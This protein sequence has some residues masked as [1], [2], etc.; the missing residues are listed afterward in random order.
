[1]RKKS[2]VLVLAVLIIFALTGC[3]QTRSYIMGMI[4][5]VPS[6]Y[7]YP[8]SRIGRNEISFIGEGLS[9]ESVRQSELVA[10][11]NLFEKL[12]EYVGTELGR[13]YYRDL[14][15]AGAIEDLALHVVVTDKTYLE[16]S[17]QYRTILLC[18]ASEEIM[19][20]L[21]TESRQ[22]EYNREKEVI[23]LVDEGDQCIKNSQDL[24]AVRLYLQ[25]MILSHGLENLED[26]YDYESILKEV[27]QILSTL[28]MKIVSSNQ[29]EA[30]CSVLVERRETILKTK[31]DMAD[32]LASY[33]CVDG[34]GN[35]WEDS[36]AFTSDSDGVFRFRSVNYTLT[37]VGQI[38]FTFNIYDEIS[39]IRAF[40]E[41]T[42]E[43]LSR[44]VEEKRTVFSYDKTLN[45]TLMGLVVFTYDS[46][47]N[48]EENQNWSDYL[49]NRLISDSLASFKVSYTEQADLNLD[50]DLS[51]SEILSYLLKIEDRDIETALILRMGPLRQS[52]AAGVCHTVVEGKAVFYFKLDSSTF[53][54]SPVLN[55]SGFGETAEEAL[56]NAYKNI[57]NIIYDWLKGNYV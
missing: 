12:E 54:E 43:E 25:S 48:R 46:S 50:G 20:N 34:L 53:R 30:S 5:D 39:G 37:T 42:A 16:K 15:N 52:T 41:E 18:A 4:K 26:G 56:T 38:V 49:Q 31:V 27:K 40:D 55:V 23:A 19:T 9:A 44:L 6:W 47:W 3:A 11:N 21:R 51:D 1:M 45:S 14:I 29:V 24:K 10:Y 35:S 28:S 17:G 8:Q 33:I 2:V 32:V 57:C 7:Y 36:Y 13:E 22:E